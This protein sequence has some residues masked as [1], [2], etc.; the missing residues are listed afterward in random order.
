MKH[1]TAE[2]LAGLEGLLA[3]LRA[4]PGLRERGTGVFYRRSRA[5][6]HFHEHDGRVYADLRLSGDDFDRHPA[7]TRAEQRALLRLIRAGISG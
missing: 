5:F 7:T 2:A 6:L 4:L 1:A 3:S